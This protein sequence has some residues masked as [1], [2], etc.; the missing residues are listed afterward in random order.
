MSGRNTV[1]LE[2]KRARGYNV[3]REVLKM[4]DSSPGSKDWLEFE[5]FT[6][7]IFNS[8]PGWTTQ[9]TSATGDQGIDV[10]A[11]SPTG[12]PYAIQCKKWTNAIGTEEAQRTVG[13]GAYRGATPAD[14]ILLST[15]SSF[16]VT[17]AFT[18]QCREYAQKTGLRLWTLDQLNEVATAA[19]SGDDLALEKLGFEL[20]HPEPVLAVAPSLEPVFESESLSVLEIPMSK[21]AIWFAPWLWVAALT[22]IAVGGFLL[23]IPIDDVKLTQLV[24]KYENIRANANATS[25]PA[26]LSE[27]MTGQ[28][29]QF[30][31]GE[32]NKRKSRNCTLEMDLFKM[33]RISIAVNGNTASA[34]YNRNDATAEHCPEKQPK[35]ISEAGNYVARF[36]FLRVDGRWLISDRQVQ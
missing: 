29:L 25:D 1:F 23:T 5:N 26:Q 8:L 19:E 4:Q 14:C 6:A 35:I 3:F 28:A 22:A 7:E 11:I 32:I 13:G 30:Q 21:K 31:T 17:K 15:H 10:V 36:D 33:E 24:A 16:D 12:R 27:V 18:S 34:L 9:I 20:R 2:P